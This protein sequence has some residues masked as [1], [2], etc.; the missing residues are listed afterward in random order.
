MKILK[1]VNEK[2]KNKNI[3]LINEINK[4]SKKNSDLINLLNQKNNNL[5]R[6][7]QETNKKNQLIEQSPRGGCAPSARTAG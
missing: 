3:N 4:I 6:L 2:L 1:L 7:T 5:I